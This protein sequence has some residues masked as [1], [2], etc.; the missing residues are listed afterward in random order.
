MQQIGFTL[1]YVILIC[2]F[3]CT[4]CIILAGFMAPS[5]GTAYVNGFN[6]N[7]KMDNI[8]KSLGLCPQHD[9]LFDTMTVHEHLTFYSKVT[10]SLSSSYTLMPHSLCTMMPHSLC[11]MM[12]HFHCT[13]MSHFHCVLCYETS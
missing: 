6:I 7:T 2:K 5:S 8:R 9:V 1:L 4:C 11:T 10:L 3:L 13:M 12:S